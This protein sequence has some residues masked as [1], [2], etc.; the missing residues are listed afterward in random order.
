M[1]YSRK[2]VK[3]SYAEVFFKKGI[4]T[5]FRDKRYRREHPIGIYFADFAWVKKKKVI[6]ID[7]K[8][9]LEKQRK[10]KDERKD[11]FLKKSGWK[12]LRIKFV[13]LQSNPRYWFQKADMFIGPVA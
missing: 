1:K 3:P 2:K 5:K 4:M 10:E 9:H 8:Y 11:E 12:V 7:G 13:D 6:E